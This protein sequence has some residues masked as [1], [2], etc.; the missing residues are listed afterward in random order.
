MNTLAHLPG[1][2]QLP[3]QT[4]LPHTLDTKEVLWQLFSLQVRTSAFIQLE[5]I[6]HCSLGD[7]LERKCQSVLPTENSDRLQSAIHCHMNAIEA[8]RYKDGTAHQS[9]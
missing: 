5:L 2:P 7:A 1:V 4:V 6:R 8:V 9:L 3:H